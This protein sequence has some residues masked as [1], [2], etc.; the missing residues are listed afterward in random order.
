M[1]SS[2]LGNDQDV[3]LAISTRPWHPFRQHHQRLHRD[4]HTGLQL[5]LDILAQFHARFPTVV[6]AEHPEAVAVAERT[7]FQKVTLPVHFVELES[8][9]LA[10]GARL[11][12][13]QAAQMHGEVLLNIAR[14]SRRESE[15]QY[16]SIAVVAIY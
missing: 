4:H 14:A 1:L 9:I 8:D 7:V 10:A 15:C 11:D 3:V 5:R 12:K 2:I 6:M 13:F 16:G